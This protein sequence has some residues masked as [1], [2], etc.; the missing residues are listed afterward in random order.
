MR[1]DELLGQ[2]LRLIEPRRE[3]VGLARVGVVEIL[4]LRLYE[5]AKV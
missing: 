4:G 3:R 5:L 1:K 2:A